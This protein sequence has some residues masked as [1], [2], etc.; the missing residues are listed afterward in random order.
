MSTRFAGGSSSRWTVRSGGIARGSSN[1]SSS[2][3]REA[4]R[5]LAVGAE[6]CDDAVAW[7]R[8]EVAER[9]QPEPAEQIA[10]LGLVEDVDGERREE[11]AA[12][13]SVRRLVRGRRRA[14][15][16]TDRRRSPSGSGRRCA[17]DACGSSRSCRPRRRRRARAAP[18]RRRST[19]PARAHATTHNPGRT[20]STRGANVSTTVT[21]RSNVRASRAGSCSSTSSSGHRDCASRRR[22]LR[23][24]PNA[25]ASGE[26]DTARLAKNTAAGVSGGRSPRH[27]RPARCAD[28]ERADHAIRAGETPAPPVSRSGTTV[29]RSRRGSR[30]RRPGARASC[31]SDAPPRGVR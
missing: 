5:D 23:F 26:T 27:D 6:A 7:E 15:R 1:R 22:M 21:M 9:P 8:R 25:S 14:T 13:R 3:A 12:R 30:L 31:V 4:V 18:P 16:R 17:A 2:R 11:L 28:G 10:Q 19:A 29:R 20:T 24:T